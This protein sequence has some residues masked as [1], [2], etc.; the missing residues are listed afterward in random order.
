MPVALLAAEYIRIRVAGALEPSLG[1]H[2]LRHDRAM[3]GCSG[4]GV[5]YQARC[6]LAKL[7]YRRWCD[8]LTSGAPSYPVG[9][10]GTSVLDVVEVEPADDLTVVVDEDEERAVACVL[11]SERVLE[12]R[13]ELFEERVATVRDRGSEVRAV[14]SFEGQYRFA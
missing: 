5:Q 4:K 12:T 7:A 6:D 8:A 2:L 1:K 10:L 9:D 3:G 11:L 13:S 14:V